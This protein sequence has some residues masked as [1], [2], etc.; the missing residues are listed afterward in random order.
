MSKEEFI[1]NLR[2]ALSVSLDHETVNK[3]IVYYEEYIMMELK[4]KKSEEEILKLLG[5]PRLLAKTII[6]TN[7]GN[8]RTV[9]SEYN[10]QE[11]ENTDTYN[12]KQNKYTKMK[13][14]L[15]FWFILILICV[16]LFFVL[17]IAATLFFKFLPFIIVGGVVLYLVKLF[18]K[19]R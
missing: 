7:Q 16:C 11:N 8:G 3:H 1:E 12:D 4:N 10:N 15:I 13:S 2:R 5:D 17:K 6:N 18:Q 9:Q 19:N 14:K